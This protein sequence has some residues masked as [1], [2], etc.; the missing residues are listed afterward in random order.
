MKDW[1]CCASPSR[2][3]SRSRTSLRR[4]RALAGA[5]ALLCMAL[6]ASAERRPVLDQIAVPHDYYY[7]EMYLPQLTSGPSGVAFTPDGRSLVYSM[8]GSLWIQPLDSGTAT[9]LTVG[10]GTT[11]SRM[12]LP[13]ASG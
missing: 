1:T 9:Q 12:S 10:P 11:I 3:Y 6:G 5:S 2:K 4:L 7:R 8:Q 13:T